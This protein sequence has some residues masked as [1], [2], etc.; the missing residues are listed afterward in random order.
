MDKQENNILDIREFFLPQENENEKQNGAVLFAID[1]GEYDMDIAM[2]E[3]SELANARGLQTLAIVTQKREAAERATVLGI[4]RLEEGRMLCMNLNATCAIFDNELSGS[5]I[6]NIE[7]IL[8]VPVIDRTMLILEIF[9]SRAV[10]NE[11]KIQTELAMLQYRLPRLVGLGESLSRQAGGGGGGGG[12]RRGAG[13]SRLEYDRRHI[14]SRIDTLRQKLKNIKERRN[15]TRKSRQKSTVST[16][17]L[18]GYTNVG[19]SSLLNCICGADVLEKDMLFA[20][21]DPTARH[22]KLP[23]GTDAVFIDTV[24]FVS[25]LPHN[26]VKAFHSTLEEATYADLIIKVCDAANPESDMQL[27]VTD[28]VLQQLNCADIPQLTV[29]NKADI[30]QNAAPF[31]TNALFVSA[32]T[33]QGI[34]NLLLRIE[35]ELMHKMC[36]MQVL[37]PYDKLALINCVRDY[38]KVLK[39]EYRENGV[40]FEGSLRRQDAHILLPYVTEET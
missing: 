20:T 7:K 15:L 9:A 13:E 34:E 22:T 32:K 5:Q 19:K 2:A 1:T 10:T 14:R 8:K 17:A 12:A 26:L 24:G 4:G 40:Y 11:G 29:Y 33:K 18:I 39:E 35:K 36:V 21:L 27:S 38:G 31:N 25:R 3:L 28:E 23:G 30:V 6:K 16:I 37:L